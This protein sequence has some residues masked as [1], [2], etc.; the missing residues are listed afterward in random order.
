MSIASPPFIVHAK[1]FG[2]DNFTFLY[3]LFYYMLQDKG[4]LSFVMCH[5]LYYTFLMSFKI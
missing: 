4:Q 5:I 3:V 2:E 1:H